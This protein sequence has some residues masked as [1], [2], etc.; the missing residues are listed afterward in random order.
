MGKICTITPT[1]DTS[2]YASGDR[3]GS[4]EKL[5]EAVRFSSGGGKIVSIA[6]VDV[7]KAKPVFDLLIFS[8]SPTVASADNAA[9]DITDAE[10]VAKFQGFVSIASGDWSDL[11]G[12]S[13]VSLKNLNLR[14]QAGAGSKDLYALCFSKGTPTFSAA[15]ALTIKV[16]IEQD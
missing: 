12:S 5:A 10:M 4:V 1:L 15:T 8:A 9:L 6:I 2:V 14:V 7:L 13:V 3:M 11:S 16:N